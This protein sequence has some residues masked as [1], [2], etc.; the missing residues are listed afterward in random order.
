ML[1]NLGLAL[2]AVLSLSAC[3]S[4]T[5]PDLYMY[6]ADGESEPSYVD[7][8]SV[9]GEAVTPVETQSVADDAGDDAF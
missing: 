5:G 2:A 6:N 8:S 3:S 7:G 9:R 1:R 4:V